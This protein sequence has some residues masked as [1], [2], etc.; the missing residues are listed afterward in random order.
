MAKEILIVSNRIILQAAIFH[1]SE[2][3]VHSHLFSKLFP[4]STFGRALLRV[5]LHTDFSE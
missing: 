1:F 2:A 3:A 5:K 4:E